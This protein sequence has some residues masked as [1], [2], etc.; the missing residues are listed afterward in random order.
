MRLEMESII[1]DEPNVSFIKSKNLTMTQMKS[2]DFFK[3][4][5]TLR[6][7]SSLLKKI[8]DKCLEFESDEERFF[9]QLVKSKSPSV[10][11]NKLS[12]K[13]LKV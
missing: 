3:K 8:N 6:N 2:C 13:E 5:T 9:V 4:F 10:L 12:H 11:L 1:D 7:V